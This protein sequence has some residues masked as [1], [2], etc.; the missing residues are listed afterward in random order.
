MVKAFKQSLVAVAALVAAS[1]VA[2]AADMYQP[3]PE[4]FAEAG[5]SGW[6][7]RAD[8]GYSW[9]DWSGGR[10]GDG[11]IAGVG[12]GYQF[13]QYFRSDLRFD[14]GFGYEVGGGVDADVGTVIAS[15]YI[16]IPLG[17]GFTPYV[18]A[19]A[20]YGWVDFAP[21]PT[22][23][24]FAWAG[25]AGVAFDVTS[26]LAFDVGYRYRSVSVSG[27]DVADHSVMGGVRWK[28]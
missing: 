16:D 25:T 13:N 2:L 28:F 6:Y 7:L 24:G 17:G 8:A 23:D 11:P 12:V 27:P 19:G 4:Q 1:G 26:N 21:G 15:G 18:G 10:D 9:L 14:Y 20:G 22:R 5:P 3:V